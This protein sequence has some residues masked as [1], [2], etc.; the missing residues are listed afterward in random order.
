MSVLL[1]LYGQLRLRKVRRTASLFSPRF[2]FV[3]DLQ[4]GFALAERSFDLA[5]HPGNFGKFRP[6]LRFER[7]EVTFV[8]C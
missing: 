1:G 5:S 4:L 3:E 2:L 7:P 6:F 8:T